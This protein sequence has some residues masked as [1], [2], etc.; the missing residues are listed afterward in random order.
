MLVA[1]AAIIKY[2]YRITLEIRSWGIDLHKSRTWDTVYD[3]FQFWLT[4]VTAYYFCSSAREEV[5]PR[6]IAESI[7]LLRRWR[8]SISFMVRSVLAILCRTNSETLW[9][10]SSDILVDELVTGQGICSTSVVRRSASGFEIS[11]SKTQYGDCLD[12]R[13][14]RDFPLRFQSRL[15]FYHSSVLIHLQQNSTKNDANWLLG[16]LSWLIWD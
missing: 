15:W 1:T 9:T 3:S 14:T 6:F 4:L 2:Y 5:G 16:R 13:H 10:A 8:F 11:R 7:F 12:L